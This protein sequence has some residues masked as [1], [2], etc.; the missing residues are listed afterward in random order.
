MQIAEFSLKK[1]IDE[2]SFDAPIRLFFA[3]SLNKDVAIIDFSKALSTDPTQEQQL[4]AGVRCFHSEEGFRT[5]LEVVFQGCSLSYKQE[6]LFAVSL[7]VFFD[8]QV[9]IADYSTEAEFL[10]VLPNQTL[11][12]TY[13]ISNNDECFDVAVAEDNS[14]MSLNVYLAKLDPV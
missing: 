8:T 11:I 4:V 6:V 9:V 3:T 2:A 5:L 1:R 14:V 12:Q 13:A 10:L 7:S